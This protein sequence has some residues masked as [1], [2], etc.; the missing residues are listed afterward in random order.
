MEF[1]TTVTGAAFLVLLAVLLGGTLSSPMSQSTK[2]MVAG[3]QLIAL[4]A[5]LA[6]GVAHGQ[7]RAGSA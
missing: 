2:L 1:D 6:L 3:G 5:V 4:V 7:W